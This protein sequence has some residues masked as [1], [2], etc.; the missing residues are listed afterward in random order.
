MSGGSVVER[1]TG[2]RIVLGS[3]PGGTSLQN[4]ANSFYLDLSVSFEGDTKNPF[5]LVSMSGGLKGKCVICRGLHTLR[6]G[7]L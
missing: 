7:Q 6:E 3:N 2:D 5:Y 4:F 1:R